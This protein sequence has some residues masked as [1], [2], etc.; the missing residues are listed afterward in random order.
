MKPALIGHHIAGLV[1]GVLRQE[2][3][4]VGD[5]ADRGLYDEL[6]TAGFG[7][8]QKITVSFGLKITKVVKGAAGSV[9]IQDPLGD[10]R[11]DAEAGKDTAALTVN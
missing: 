11:T 4:T 9:R 10:A 6:V 1:D 5:L 7:V 2:R 8:G 3:Q